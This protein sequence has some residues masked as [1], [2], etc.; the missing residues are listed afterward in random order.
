MKNYVLFILAII[1][2]FGVIAQTNVNLKQ[3]DIEPINPDKIEALAY[4]LLQEIPNEEKDSTSALLVDILS[5]SLQSKES[6]E[7]TFDKVKS[8]TILTAP[9]SSFRLFN[10]TIPYSDGTHNYEC[11]LLTRNGSNYTVERFNRL[12]SITDK[13]TLSRSSLTT[14][15]WLPGLYYKIILTENR[16]QKFYT[17]L[18]WNGNDLLTN[19]KHIEVLWFDKSGKVK[20]GAPL[21]KDNREVQQRVLFEFGG[22]NSMQ[23]NYEEEL[24]RITFSHLAPPSS[25]LEGIYEYYGADVTFDAYE[26]NGKHWKLLSE[27]IPKWADPKGRTET[28]VTNKKMNTENAANP[29]EAKRILKQSEK[30]LKQADDELKKS[31]GLN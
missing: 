1:S 4:A 16:F 13:T 20:F 2:S 3:V 12:D 14:A 6:F 5:S 25:N 9:D 17:L 23:L 10:W 11:L 8:L 24:Q 19:K 21:F 18:T 15:N 31:K 28:S 29:Q 30:E 7:H 26:W 22:Q 27:V